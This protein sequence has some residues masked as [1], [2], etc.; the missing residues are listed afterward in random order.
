MKKP[1]VKAIVI[2]L[3][4]AVVALGYS[5]ADTNVYLI[6]QNFFHEGSA[7]LAVRVIGT[8]AADIA[9]IDRAGAVRGRPIYAGTS[10]SD[11][12]YQFT[13]VPALGSGTYLI[14]LRV[15]STVYRRPFIVYRT[16][17]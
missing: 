16:Q 5:A 9:I 2:S 14:Y 1:A 11:T 10:G 13:V 15:G 8:S 4:S 17:P 7:V 6:N 12:L 3:F